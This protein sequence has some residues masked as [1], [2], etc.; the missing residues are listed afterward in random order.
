MQEHNMPMRGELAAPA[1]RL[2]RG[3][4]ADPGIFPIIA[5]CL[6]GLAISVCFALSS[7]SFDQIS[8]LI[9]QYNLM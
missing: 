1:M 5:F 3:A 9:M 6:I 7:Q 2:D 8:L 4:K